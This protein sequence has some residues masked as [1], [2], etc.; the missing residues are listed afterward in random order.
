MNCSVQRVTQSVADGHRM[1]PTPELP[2]QVN[3][4]NKEWTECDSPFL[5]VVMVMSMSGSLVT[6]IE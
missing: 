2:S 5:L 6:A 1:L 3:K 4:V